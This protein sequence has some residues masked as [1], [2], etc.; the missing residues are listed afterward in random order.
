MGTQTSNND[1]IKES[2]DKV[3]L[4]FS[5]MDMKLPCHKVSNLQLSQ[6]TWWLL[7]E[8]KHYLKFNSQTWNVLKSEMLQAVRILYKCVFHTMYISIYKLWL[9]LHFFKH[10]SLSLHVLLEFFHSVNIEISLA[11]KGKKN[12]RKLDLN[13]SSVTFLFFMIRL[14]SILSLS[15]SFHILKYG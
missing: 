9:L 7:S 12:P 4:R 2:K 13:L 15:L 14:T 11:S 10:S 6:V 1:F 3:R 8:D 5:R